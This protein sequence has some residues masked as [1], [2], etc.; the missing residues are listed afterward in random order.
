MSTAALF[1]GFTLYA[2]VK[3]TGGWPFMNI[4]VALTFAALAIIYWMMYF[5]RRN[6]QSSG[7]E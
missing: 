7:T 4:I 5:R 2:T 3:S 6:T 1:W